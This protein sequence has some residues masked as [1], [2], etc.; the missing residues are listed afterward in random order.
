MWHTKLGIRH[1]ITKHLTHSKKTNSKL[2]ACLKWEKLFEWITFFIVKSSYISKQ[3]AE[4]MYIIQRVSCLYFHSHID[5]QSRYSWISELWMELDWHIDGLPD[6]DLV[7]NMDHSVLPSS[8]M[9]LQ[10]TYYGFLWW[11][12]FYWHHP[13]FY[14]SCIPLPDNKLLGIVATMLGKD[15]A[16]K[17]IFSLPFLAG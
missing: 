4:N 9:R 16:G 14:T 15:G 6:V 5:A 10:K 13:Q 17:I 11:N 12:V 3:N 1:I 2:H 7:C 8:F